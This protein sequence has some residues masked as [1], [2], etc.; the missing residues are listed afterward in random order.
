MNAPTCPSDWCNKAAMKMTAV[1]RSISTE[2]KQK[3]KTKIHYSLLHKVCG[4]TWYVSKT[5]NCCKV[6]PATQKIILADT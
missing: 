2:K 4:V 6:K 3:A 1:S 5:H